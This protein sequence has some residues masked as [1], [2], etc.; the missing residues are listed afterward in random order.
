MR[1]IVQWH[2]N[3]ETGCQFWLEWAE[4][5]GWNP[6]EEVQS[7][8]DLDERFPDFQDEY[9][10]DLQPEFWRPKGE[11]YNNRPFSIVETGGTTGMPK[12]RI[13]WDTTKST[14]APSLRLLTMTTFQK[15]ITGL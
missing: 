11:P 7:L 14:T 6:A 2:F 13:G 3:P 15:T 10:R 9:L 4:K 5:Q 12:Q 8:E 1:E